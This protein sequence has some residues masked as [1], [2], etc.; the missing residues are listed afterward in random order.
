MLNS[1]LKIL[2]EFAKNKPFKVV[3][4]DKNV[5]SAVISNNLYNSLVMDILN[6][7]LVYREVNEDPLESCLDLIHDTLFV[8][9]ES[10]NISKRLYKTLLNVNGK[11]G[12]FRILP[13]IHK[14]KFSCRPI[15]NYKNHVTTNLCFLVDFICR[16]FVK[17]SESFI[18][19]SQNLIQKL[20]NILFPINSEII[21]GDFEALYSNI[22]HDDCLLKLTDFVNGKL[23]S[24]HI[25][26]K[27]FYVVLK[28]VLKNNYFTYNK[29][30]FI[31]DLG[32]AMGSI[33]GPTIANLFVQIYEIK[34]TTI[35]RPLAYYRFIDDI[36]LIVTDLVVVDTLKN[37]FG[38]LKLNLVYKKRQVF[39]DLE[40][41]LNKFTNRINFFAHFKP[42]NTFSYLLILSN[43]PNHIFKNLI[44]ALFIR[45][46]RICTFFSDFLYFASILA[47]RLEKRGYDRILINKT[48][49]MVSDLSRDSL[50]QYKEKK[51]SLNFNNTFVFR[52]FYDKN[53]INFKKVLNS[54]FTS[55]KEIKP[56]YKDYNIFL[57]NKMQSNLSALLIHNF[58]FPLNF[59]NSYKKCK[60]QNCATCLYSNNKDS[61]NLTKNFILPIFDNSDIFD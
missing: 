48:L 46:R 28:L 13:K 20:E 35:Y 39:L 14:S 11:L 41:E 15:I 54:A 8:N 55:F 19:D 33:C 24:K 2:K 18:M 32:I 50:I 36:F 7:P 49:M 25:N 61:V 57:I 6:D 27:G 40:I 30:F 31:Q 29:K 10:K 38:S 51:K 34:W 47:N 60:E 5:G 4:L 16:P 58:K 21:T 52:H 23:K 26:V 3:E 42:T 59:K 17:S 9:F 12:N 44:K 43:H 45:M 1:E 56:A 22:D 37:A 53:I